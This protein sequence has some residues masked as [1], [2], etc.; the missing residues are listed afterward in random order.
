MAVKLRKPEGEVVTSPA[1]ENTP[2]EPEAPA[3]TAPAAEPPKEPEVAKK[4]TAK[5][6]AKKSGGK[7]SSK[8]PTPPKPV[9]PTAQAPASRNGAKKGPGKGRR[10]VDFDELPV[11]V[12]L[13]RNPVVKGAFKDEKAA[14]KWIETEVPVHK[15]ALARIGRFMPVVVKTKIELS[16]E[17]GK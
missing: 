15:R 9:A 1:V 3:Q 11:G 5:K 4:E 10:A 16:V 12:I 14:L 8:K 17:N 6:P 7:K 13:G 2:K